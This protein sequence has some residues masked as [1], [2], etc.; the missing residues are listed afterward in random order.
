MFVFKEG[1]KHRSVLVASALG[2]LGTEVNTYLAQESGAFRKIGRAELLLVARRPVSISAC[3]CASCK[4]LFL[5]WPTCLPGLS[6]WLTPTKNSLL[7]ESYFCSCSVFVFLL[8]HWNFRV[9][10]FLYSVGHIM[11]YLSAT[12]CQSSFSVSHRHVQKGCSFPDPESTLNLHFFWSVE[13]RPLAP[14]VTFIIWPPSSSFLFFTAFVSICVFLFR[15]SLH[16]LLRELSTR[17]FLLLGVSS[18][19]DSMSYPNASGLFK[20]PSTLFLQER[21]SDHSSHSN[22][23]FLE[24]LG[25]MKHAHSRHDIVLCFT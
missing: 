6:L 1:L 25:I 22:L 19:F 18:P 3:M 14:L 10:L 9:W 21:L 23:S 7:K 2:A 12:S 11:A 16:W 13:S 15:L 5:F 17:W 20:M 24:L 8:L 4:M